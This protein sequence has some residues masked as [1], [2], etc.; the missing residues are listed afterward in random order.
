M[1]GCS[2]TGKAKNK[3]EL[4][5]NIAD[6]DASSVDQIN[7]LKFVWTV[8]DMDAFKKLYEQEEPEEHRFW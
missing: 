2:A 5:F 3:D 1:S 4:T 6:A 8:H 7:S